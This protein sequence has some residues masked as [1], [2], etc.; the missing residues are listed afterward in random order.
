MIVAGA[1]EGVTN[2]EPN[3]FH[4]NSS[5]GFVHAFNAIYSTW[6]GGVTN[7]AWVKNCEGRAGVLADIFLLFTQLDTP[8]L[9]KGCRSSRLPKSFLVTEVSAGQNMMT[10][11]V[12]V[13]WACL[14][15]M[16]CRHAAGLTR[17][18]SLTGRF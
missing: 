6:G 12:V 9:R 7:Y 10:P 14:Q 8:A 16:F 4:L 13:L 11:V 1:G 2:Y 15:Q 5:M 3:V 18:V 17:G